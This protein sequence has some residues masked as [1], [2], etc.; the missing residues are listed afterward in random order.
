M[1]EK[2]LDSHSPYIKSNIHSIEKTRNNILS[3]A[4]KEDRET[5]D[6]LLRQKIT[7]VSKKIV[8]EEIKKFAE[9]ASREI[10]EEFSNLENRI[11]KNIHESLQMSLSENVK[12]N[13]IALGHDIGK[14][15]DI[16]M[17]ELNSL[18]TD[19]EIKL[20]NLD[21]FSKSL[22]EKIEEN[23]NK[24]NT[25]NISY[26]PIFKIDTKRKDIQK[27]E[28]L[29]PEI[30]EEIILDNKKD[31]TKEIEV[32]NNEIFEKEKEVKE[33]PVDNNDNT[34]RENDYINE[35]IKS[36]IAKF[37]KNGF[38]FKKNIFLSYIRDINAKDFLE[39]KNDY[40]DLD[41]ADKNKIKEILENNIKELNINPEEKEN[42]EDFL[43]RIY[44]IKFKK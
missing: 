41:E 22:D 24:E 27:E 6:T 34:L 7:N 43:K 20:E 30:K 23:K 37:E 35:N 31:V 3:F 42:I 19:M 44:S 29:T 9:V 32:I 5:S 4:N 16:K 1:K 18:I 40:K 14:E 10:S 8:G 2:Y 36:I 12:E 38:L 15:L 33:I 11:T 25:E 13:V 21:N 28:K 17:Q 26:E 39:N